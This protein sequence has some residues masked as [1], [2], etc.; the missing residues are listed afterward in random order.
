MRL[1]V[2]VADLLSVS[3]AFGI[4]ALSAVLLTAVAIVTGILG[5]YPATWWLITG[6]LVASLVVVFI[7]YANAARERDAR[8]VR[9]PSGPASAA[10]DPSARPAAVIDERDGSFTIID[11]L[12]PP[13]RH[14]AQA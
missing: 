9:D 7:A 5:V 4:V 8:P 13:V 6:T 10:D 11:E 2:W 3:S 1:R 14:Q 12:G